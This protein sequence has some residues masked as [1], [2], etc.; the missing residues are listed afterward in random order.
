MEHFVAIFFRCSLSSNVA[1]YSKSSPVMSIFQDNAYIYPITQKHLNVQLQNLCYW[2]LFFFHSISYL[3]AIFFPEKPQR[4]LFLTRKNCLKTK[5]P[6]YRFWGMPIAMVVI[7][8]LSSEISVCM[9][10][11]QLSNKP[12]GFLVSV[13]SE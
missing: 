13:E 9:P 10:C 4:K 1:K 11:F 2:S 6:T 7:G 5:V 3:V 8:S 12:T